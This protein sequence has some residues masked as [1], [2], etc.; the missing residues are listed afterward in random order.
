[1]FDFTFRFIVTTKKCFHQTD[2]DTD[3][4][5]G[6][7]EQLLSTHLECCTLFQVVVC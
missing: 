4:Q 5:K 6:I 2:V 3:D 1:M 7:S